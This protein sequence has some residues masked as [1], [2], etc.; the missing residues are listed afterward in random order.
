M[1]NK[2]LVFIE[3][4][5]QDQNKIGPNASSVICLGNG[6][7]AYVELPAKDMSFDCVFVLSTCNVVVVSMLN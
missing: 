7:Y 1:Y 4:C 2:R 6:Q 3:I 5:R